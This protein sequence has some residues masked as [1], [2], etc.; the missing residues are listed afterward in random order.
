[1]SYLNVITLAAAKNYLRVDEGLTEDDARITSMI[2]AVLS[3]IERRTNVLVYARSKSY[4]VQ[5]YEV[6]VY[7]FPINSL[8][9]PTTAILVEKELHNNYTTKLSTELKVV[10]DVGYADPLDVP[11]E[12][13]E[14]ALEY[15]KYLYYDSETNSGASNKIPTYIEYMIES[16]KRFII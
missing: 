9:S 4:L 11:A 7:D 10:L 3:M 8:T 14:C 2:K 12:I 16:Q 6:R 5:D 15:L 13:V 1:M